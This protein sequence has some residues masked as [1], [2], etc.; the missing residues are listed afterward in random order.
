[1]SDVRLELGESDGAAVVERARGGDA[2]SPCALAAAGRRRRCRPDGRRVPVDRSGVRPTSDRPPT[3]VSVLGP[4]GLTMFFDSC[5]SAISP[6]GRALA[7]TGV[8]P[9]GA[10]KM[11]VRP[12]ARTRRASAGGHRRRPLAVL[13]AGQP[14][15][16]VL[17]GRQAEEG[18]RRRRDGG[19]DG[20]RQGRPRRVLGRGR[21]DRVRAVEQRAAPER[22]GQWRRAEGRD[23]A[24]CGEGR[25]GPSLP[26]VSARR[27][28]FP[29][30]RDSGTQSEIRPLRRVPGRRAAQP[31][32]S[33]EGSAVYA[34][35]GY[36]LFARKNA[37]VAQRFDARGV[38][39]SGEPIAI[40]DVPARWARS[41][42]P[43]RAVSVSATGTLA[44]LGDKLQQHET[45]LVRSVRTGTGQGRDA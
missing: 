20:R 6:D 34:E 7:F 15:R 5:D 14:A 11:W 24:R 35:P 13:V 40:G 29:V 44:Y 39:L 45:R 10:F 31:I 32:G 43:S 27:S 3:R 26:L 30:R 28:P 16:R 12:L 21:R 37:L 9:S 41:S 36:L 22:V 33:S 42:R 19:N 17:H 8:D 25:N 4:E 38:A 18:A 23:R 1:M 2:P